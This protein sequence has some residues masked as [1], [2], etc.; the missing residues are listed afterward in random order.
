LQRKQSAIQ[1]N[2][3]QRESAQACVC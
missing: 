2:V 1:F 3:G